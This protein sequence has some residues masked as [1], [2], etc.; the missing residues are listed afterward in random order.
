MELKKCTKC[1]E[2]KALTDY[3]EDRRWGGHRSWC[4]ACQKQYFKAYRLANQSRRAAHDR[5]WG[6]RNAAKR[7]IH[8]AHHRAKLKGLPFDLWNHVDEIKERLAARRCEL[9]FF[10]L[11]D[12]P[13]DGQIRFN[14]PSLDRIIPELGYVYDNTRIV[15]NCLNSGMGNWGEGNL[16]AVARE[17]VKRED[18]LDRTEGPIE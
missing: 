7:L 16:L 10:P 8:S 12:A 4:K 15:C 11:L 6:F 14:S 3:Y 2:Q 1:G 17:W 9:S 13:P 18:E 5:A